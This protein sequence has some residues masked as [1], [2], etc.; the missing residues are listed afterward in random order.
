V[1]TT[2]SLRTVVLAI[3]VV[4]LMALPTRGR[5]QDAV[6]GCGDPSAPYAE[7]QIDTYPHLDLE[8]ARTPQEHELGLMYRDSLPPDSGM[9]FVYQADSREGYW[10]YHT[11][12][13]LS[14]AWI[15]R[16]GTIVDIQDMPRLNDPNDMAEAS[17][18]VYNPA[19]PYRYALEVNEGWFVQHG[20]GVGQQMLFCLG[21]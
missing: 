19:A 17:R 12:I 1:L 11:L 20:V 15:D 3:L 8:I 2:S 18:T 13:P 7:V 4:G 16:D 14:I 6:A 5:A 10:M 9:L 21:A